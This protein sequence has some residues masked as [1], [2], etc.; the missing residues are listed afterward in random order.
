M[1]MTFNTDQKQG[2]IVLENEDE[3]NNIM[4][5]NLETYHQTTIRL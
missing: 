4:K 3:E 1:F 2:Y 5:L